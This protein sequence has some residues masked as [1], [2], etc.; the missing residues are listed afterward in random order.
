VLGGREK[1]FKEID[2]QNN[3]V[4]N[5]FYHNMVLN[6]FEDEVV[7]NFSVTYLIASLNGFKEAL[8]KLQSGRNHL[9]N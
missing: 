4:R 3:I 6:S 7:F 8:A 9:K 1:S 5:K 2:D